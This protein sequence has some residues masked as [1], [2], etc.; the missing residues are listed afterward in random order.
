MHQWYGPSN[1]N[2]PNRFSLAWNYQVPDVNHAL[3]LVGRV[4]S[5]WIVSGT[6]IVQSGYPF[7]V[8]TNASFSPLTNSS[9][10]YIGYAPGSGDYNA[11][12]DN[13]DFPNVTSYAQGTGHR[14]FLNGV[15][16]TANFPQPSFGSEGNEA[17]NRFTGPNFNES[18]VALLKNTAIREGIAFQFR[19]EFFNVFNRPNLTSMDTNLPDGNFGKATGQ[20]APRFIQIGGNLTF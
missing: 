4:A 11:D 16:T 10:T 20:L 17:F 18:D 3:G 14:A 1:W 13:F 9:G 6:T 7:V 8:S 15:F 12:G 5:G 19:F 2:A